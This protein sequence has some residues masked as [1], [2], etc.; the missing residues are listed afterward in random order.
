[1]LI[2][3]GFR[4]VIGEIAPEVDKTPAYLADP[5]RLLSDNA[6]PLF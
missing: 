4:M 2:D 1:M 6:P 5:A 3:H